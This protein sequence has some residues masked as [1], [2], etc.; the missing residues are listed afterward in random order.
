MTYEERVQELIEEGLDSG[1][2]QAVV[3]AEDLQG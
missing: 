3:Y 2:A 1:D